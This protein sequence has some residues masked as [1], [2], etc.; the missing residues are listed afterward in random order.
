MTGNT[1]CL[2]VKVLMKDTKTSPI[3]WPVLTGCAHFADFVTLWPGAGD[4]LEY[5]AEGPFYGVKVWSLMCVQKQYSLVT[6]QGQKSMSRSDLMYSF[7]N[8]SA[9][10]TWPPDCS[11]TFIFHHLYIG[12]AIDI[13]SVSHVHDFM[14]AQI[15]SWINIIMNQSRNHR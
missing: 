1:W 9:P 4:T 10:K 15:N 5:I 13:L 6:N 3:A 8:Q 7:D 12:Y 11:F 2:F 14:S